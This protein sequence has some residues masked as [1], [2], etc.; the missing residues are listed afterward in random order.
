MTLNYNVI[1]TGSK[2]NAVRIENVMIDCGIPFKRMR[3]ELYKVDTLLL[4]HTHSDHIKPQTLEHIRKEFPRIRV[5]GNWEVAQA[6]PVDK[7]I[8]EKPFEL[9][10]GNVT[11]YPFYGKHDVTVTGFVIDF[12]GTRVFY[13]TDTREV[14]NP[15][16]YTMD[17]VFI[18]CN[19][20]EKKL[21]KL[22]KTYTHKGYDPTANAYRHLSVRKAKEF[23]YSNRTNEEAPM[24]ELHQSERF[25]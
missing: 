23:Y 17:Y 7:I 24:I 9:K 8:G 22:A 4:T 25:R 5:Y 12:D 18:E 10:R 6:Y 20:D 16:E 15:T 3:D 14:M 13:A 21:K 2:G 11:V 19:Y 1:A